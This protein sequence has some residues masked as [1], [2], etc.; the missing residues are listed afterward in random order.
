[1]S[2]V[3]QAAYHSIFERSVLDRLLSC[4]DYLSSDSLLPDSTPTVVGADTT[5]TYNGGVLT[6]D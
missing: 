2:F 1:M 4:V 6:W 5:Q 3:P